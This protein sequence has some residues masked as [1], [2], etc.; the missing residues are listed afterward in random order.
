L[1]PLPR[2]EC[3]PFT[4]AWTNVAPVFLRDTVTGFEPDQ[5]TWFKTAWVP[6]ELRVFFHAEDNDAWASLTEHDAP[7]YQEEVVEIFLDPFGDLES[8]FEIEINP[9]NAVC[10]LVLRKTRSGW[11]KNFAWHCE[12]L[13]TIVTKRDDAWTVEISIPFASLAPDL[14]AAGKSWRAN[15]CRIDRPKNSQRE[16]SAWSPTGRPFFHVQQKF[17]YLDFVR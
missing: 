9:L 2:L 4:G 3:K 14:S 1:N 8:Y 17:G 11:R 5:I 10:D 13:L 6:G 15:F 12:D 7:L 16:L